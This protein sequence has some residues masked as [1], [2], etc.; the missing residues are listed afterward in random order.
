MGT[1]LPTID[2]EQFAANESDIS[3]LM[4]HLCRELVR[5]TGKARLPQEAQSKESY[6][7]LFDILRLSRQLDSMGR[8][9]ARQCIALRARPA[10]ELL[11]DIHHLRQQPG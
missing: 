11:L 4:V 10:R 5:G 3:W 7:G 6:R 8:P 2:F 9:G 1:G